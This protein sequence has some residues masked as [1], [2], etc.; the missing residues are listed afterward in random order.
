MDP[1]LGFSFWKFNIHYYALLIILGAIVAAIIAAWQARKNGRD[2]EVIVDLMPWLLIG[3]IIGARLW[4]VFT[5]GVYDGTTASYFEDPIK[6]LQIWKGGLGIPGGVIG[7]AIALWLYTKVK[8]LNFAEWAD[9]IAPGLLIGQGIGRWGNFINQELYGRPSNLPWAI[10]IDPLYRIPG[11]ELIERYHP[12]FLY[13]FILNTLAGI[14]LLIISRVCKKKLYKGD[15][16]LLYLVFY[17]AIRFGLEF[18]RLVP[19]LT[20]SGININ[21]TVMLVVMILAIIALILRHTILKPKQ[22]EETAEMLVDE[23]VLDG[24]ALEEAVDEELVEEVAELD[25]L[26]AEV[27]ETVDTVESLAEE[28]EA[29]ISEDADELVET[30]EETVIPDADS[31]EEGSQ[32]PK[33]LPKRNSHNATQDTSVAFSLSQNLVVEFSP[34]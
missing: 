11:F 25:R 1:R 2:S 20:K 10:K 32:K 14:L 13:E 26:D 4:H 22:E 15:L 34:R 30:I 17:P 5:P 29:K 9:Y 31:T 21:Q 8:K 27:S 18:V 12:L 19:S 23:A 7:G 28:T 33:S 3:G 6:I 24:E 16:I